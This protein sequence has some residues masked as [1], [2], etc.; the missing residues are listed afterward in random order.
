MASS[1]LASGV[2]GTL[3]SLL[4]GGPASKSRAPIGPDWLHR[5]ALR[6]YASCAGVVSGASLRM[7]RLDVTYKPQLA[8]PTAT[9]TRARE[10]TPRQCRSSGFASVHEPIHAC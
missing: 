8:P 6:P 10:Q 1:M 3:R 9:A 2:E 4:W 7:C 5:T